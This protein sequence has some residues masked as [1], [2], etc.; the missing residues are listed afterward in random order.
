MRCAI[1][2]RY[3]TDMQSPASIEDQIRNCR[4]FAHNQGWQVLDNRIYSDRAVSGASKEARR[5][6]GEMV[7]LALSPECDFEIILADDTSR[8]ARDIVDQVSVF[9]EL[10]YKG[11]ALVYVSQGIDT[12]HEDAETLLTVHGLVDGLYIRELAK[13]T[14]RGMAGKVLG[15]MSAGGKLFGYRT[16]PV[17]DPSGRLDR[18]GN[19]SL[20]G[21]RIMIDEAEAAVVRRIFLLYF[22]GTSLRG[23]ARKL[24]SEGISHPGKGRKRE[25]RGWAS[26]SVRAILVNDKYVGKWWWNK[27]RWVKRPGTNKHKCIPRP[28]EEWI[29]GQREELRIIDQELWDN[30]H[31]RRAQVSAAYRRKD[32]GSLSGQRKETVY[33]R[34]ILSGLLRCGVCGG[35]MIIAGRDYYACSNHRNKGE[36]VCPNCRSVRRTRLEQEIVDAIQRELLSPSAVKKVIERARQ[37]IEEGPESCLN[38]LE[39]RRAEVNYRI[40]NLIEFIAQGQQSNAVQIA[41]AESESQLAKLDEKIKRERSVSRGLQFD[42]NA[43][44]QQLADLG[45][46][47]SADSATAGK[48]LKTIIDTVTVIPGGYE[49]G[50]D[51]KI[52]L[53]GGL[54]AALSTAGGRAEGI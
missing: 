16:E 2:A 24:N 47:L 37:Q 15:N 51:Q 41:L 5:A 18:H 26:S 49:R 21:H 44:R 39:A 52:K 38:E 54:T 19:P 53:Q 48:A 43:I 1:Y 40:S 7:S 45:E 22:D 36:S 31:E 50:Q 14:H 25:A 42:A 29:G 20:L 8:L 17:P 13:K 35:N 33:S 11:V 6:F 9:R 23:I 46:L 34:Y 32:D 12:R 28:R 30:V 3:S 10:K 4:Q 27:T